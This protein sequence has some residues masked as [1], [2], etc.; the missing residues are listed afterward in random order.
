MNLLVVKVVAKHAA[1]AAVTAA[2]AIV[3]RDSFVL[4]FNE[5]K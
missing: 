5:E 2:A 1:I 4:L 3:A